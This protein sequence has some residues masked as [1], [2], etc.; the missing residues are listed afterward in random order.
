MADACKSTYS[1][2]SLGAG[3]DRGIAERRMRLE[4]G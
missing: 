4:E 3:R 2:G 1:C